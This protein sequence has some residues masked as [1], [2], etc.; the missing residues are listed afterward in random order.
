MKRAKLQYLLKTGPQVAKQLLMLSRSCF[1]LTMV[2]HFKIVDEEYIEELKDKSK[3]ENTKNTVAWSNGRT[4]PK[5][6][7]MKGTS[8]QILKSTTGMSLT[9]HSFMHSEMQSY[10]PLCY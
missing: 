10:C 5:S 2:S 9:I 3:N 1:S 6:G 8:K 7:Q 4:F